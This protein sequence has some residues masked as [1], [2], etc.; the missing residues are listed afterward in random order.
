M[1][2]CNPLSTSGTTI[3]AILAKATEQ[4]KPYHAT[5]TLDAEVLL[6]HV[7]GVSRAYLHTW[8]EL[9]VGEEQRA[10]FYCLI[11]RRLLGEPVA[12][13][14]GRR[15]FW[16][17]ELQ[18]SRDTLIP[19]PETELLVE[20]ALQRIPEHVPWRIADLGTG[21]GAIALAL[22]LAR[23][24][25]RIIATEIS[26]AALKVARTNA[27]R[28]NV[29]NVEFRPGEADWHVPLR[30]ERFDVIVSNPPY[31]R[32]DDPLLQTGE[33]GFEP[34]IALVAGT[35][36]LQHLRSIALHASRHLA[37]DAWLLLEHGF[38]Q[39]PALVGLLSG[40]G[41]HNVRDHSDLAGH[42]RVISAQY[43]YAK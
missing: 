33:L 27:K 30:G 25:C 21:S 5:A 1:F 32:S 26:P 31:V 42:G 20:L 10:R 37:V 13:L 19:R 35:D 36:G 2:K 40:L 3:S 15:E 39:G 34:G 6:A 24:R 12:S 4:L 11:E 17:M 9:K 18:V 14:S 7:L 22:A 23:P 43:T 38:D 28:L 41:Y 8:P 16:S 29:Q